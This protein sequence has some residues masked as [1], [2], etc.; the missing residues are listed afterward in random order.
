MSQLMLMLLAM[1]ELYAAISTQLKT[2]LDGAFVIAG[3]FNRAILRTVL[4]RF[5]Q[6]VSFQDNILDHVYPD[7]PGAYKAYIPH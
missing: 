3:D 4:P 7:V 2:H 1:K 6:N 5:F